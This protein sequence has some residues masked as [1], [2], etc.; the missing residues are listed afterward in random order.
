MEALK[1]VVLA[2]LITAALVALMAYQLEPTSKGSDLSQD[3]SVP[4][5]SPNGK[6]TEVP[7][8]RARVSIAELRAACVAEARRG[9]LPGRSGTACREYEL[10]TAARG[11]PTVNMM[12]SVTP[13]PS[14]SPPQRRSSQPE[15]VQATVIAQSCESLGYGSI[16]Y[17][18]CRADEKRR[19]LR[20]CD[21]SQERAENAT[22]EMRQ[23]LKQIARENCH[24]ADLY[25]IVN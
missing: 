25:Q 10:A 9:G 23:P 14:R 17:R 6:A 20:I 12:A 7:P 2:C 16:R 8:G 24:I 15:T 3:F 21:L 18:E 19:L 13:P 11:D 1:H 5:S 22:G 4:G